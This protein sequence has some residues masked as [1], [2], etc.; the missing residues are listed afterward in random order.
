VRQN[1]L[2][3]AVKPTPEIDAVVTWVDGEDPAHRAKLNR[4]LESLGST[5][6]AARPTR[7]RSV[8]EIDYCITSLLKFAPFLRRIHIITD[9][10]T[11]PIVERSRAW[12]QLMRDKLV[13]VDH[14]Q[15]FGGLEDCLPTFNSL[16]IES[17]M[18][19]THG[20]AE[21]FVYLNDDF[22]LIKPVQPEDWFRNGWPVVRGSWKALP[23]RVL[24]QRVLRGLRN[25]LQQLAGMPPRAS[26]GDA[27][28]RAARLAG[29][30]TH[31]LVLG[32]HPHALRRSTFESFFAAHPQLLRANVEPRLR[33]AGQFLPQGLASQLELVAGTAHLE[34][35]GRVFYLKPS[36]TTLAR[37]E[38]ALNAA[39]NDP[40]LLF[41]CVQS[42]DEAAPEVQ[43][44]IAAW[45]ERVIG[46]LECDR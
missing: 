16:A 36:R 11:P 33:S 17:V 12:P 8:G 14:Q 19:R 29:S 32:H 37:L 40:R 46:R 9:A 7:F 20:L 31:Y 13:L 42:L 23:E 4:L 3:R 6:S 41:A 21:Q 22:F 39:E 28:A 18:F 24:A 34:P 30:S 15:V 26:H 38:P 44:R 43:R 45:F 27:Q 5:P 25:Q 35:D 2:G 1:P 10:Q